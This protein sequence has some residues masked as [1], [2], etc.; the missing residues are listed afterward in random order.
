MGT[1][2]AAIFDGPGRG[3]FERLQVPQEFDVKYQIRRGGLNLPH[4]YN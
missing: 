4:G 3:K 2:R 1:A